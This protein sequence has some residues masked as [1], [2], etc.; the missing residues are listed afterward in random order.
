MFFFNKPE[1]KMN[2][3]L[4]HSIYALY[5]SIYAAIKPLIV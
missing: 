3:M 5:H 1:R 4:Y 2:R